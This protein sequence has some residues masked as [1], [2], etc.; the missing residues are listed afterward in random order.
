MTSGMTNTMFTFI[1]GPTFLD[2]VILKGF[3][4]FFFV[5]SCIA[6][7]LKMKICN[8][9]FKKLSFPLKNENHRKEE[10]HHLLSIYSVARAVLNSSIIK[11]SFNPHIAAQ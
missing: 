3:I 4:T 5:L 8:F 9:Y 6:E 11:V 7:F 1:P 2:G 10:N